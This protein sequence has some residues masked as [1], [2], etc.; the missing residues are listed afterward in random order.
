MRVLNYSILAILFLATSITGSAKEKF[1]KKFHELYEV[2]QECL[3]EINNRYGNIII[4]NTDKSN[5]TIDAEIIIETASQDKADKFFS[6]IDISISK[7]GKTVKAITTIDNLKNMNTSFEINYTVKMPAYLNIILTNKYGNVNI[8]ELHG[9]S[10][11]SVKYGSLN[12][13]RI[14]DGN[15]KPLS[16]VTLGY[17]ERSHINEFNWGTLIMKYSKLE[18]V[19]G[20]ALV[21]S[22]KYSKLK[23]G[24]FSSIISN[25]SY[26]EYNVVSVKNLI[27]ESKYTDIKIDS[28]LKKLNMDNGYGG[29]DI[30]YIPDG[31]TM[32]DI[33]SKYAKIDI[34]IDEN[35]SYKLNAHTRYANI[36]YNNILIKE[37]IKESNST[38][39]KGIAG[40]KETEAEVKIE[41][42]YGNVDLR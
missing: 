17:C 39:I 22:S 2:D 15:S 38:Y 11:I 32:V 41:S 26:D 8:N 3:F 23:L 4:E 29:I 24:K 9:K 37:R 31:F 18:V 25:A 5:I 34:G 10:T 42:S 1:E 12:V 6:R 30:D 27:I 7:E 16:S 28:L 21:I 33:K 36:D 14:T 40:D 19:K 20:K 35:A 13:N